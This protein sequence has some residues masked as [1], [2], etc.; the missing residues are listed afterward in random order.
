LT[1]TKRDIKLIIDLYS[2]PG[3]Q[4][5]KSLFILLLIEGLEG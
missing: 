2:V 3:G 4:K 1:G 5:V